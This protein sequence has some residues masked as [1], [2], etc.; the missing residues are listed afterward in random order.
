MKRTL[1][2]WELAGI[3]FIVLFGSSLH[4]LFELS[5][6]WRPMALIAAV[7]ESV[8]EHFKMVFWPGL[9]WALI[10]YPFIRKLAR[11]FGIAKAVSLAAMPITIALLFYGYTAITGEHYVIVDGLIFIVAILLW[12][13]IS[14][15]LLTRP[16]IEVPWL[17]GSA[18]GVLAILIVAFSTLSY[19]PP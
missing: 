9:I 18:L 5:G 14:L 15:R 10:E 7:N 17:R 3:A 1:Q 6:Y 16:A 19:Y 2:R 11:N 4:F 8:W 13:W 12:Q